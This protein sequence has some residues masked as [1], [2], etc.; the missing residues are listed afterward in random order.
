M[1]N[2]KIFACR[3]AEDF[4]QKV[5]DEIGVELGQK[6]AFKFKND[7]TFV[8]IL[9]TVREDDIFVFQTVQPPVDERIME[10]LITLDALKRASPRRITAVVPYYPYARSDKKDQP[11]V[12]ITSKLVADL[13]VTAGADRVLTCDLHNP[14]IQG[15]IEAPSDQLRAKDILT[16][17]FRP[18]VN[19]DVS[20]FVVVAT[21]AGSSKN[22]YKYARRLGTEIALIDKQRF[23]NDDKAIASHV[24]GDVKEKTCII[25]DDEID[26]AGSMMEAVRVLKDN[27]AGDIYAACTHGVLSGDAIEKIKN[28]AL[29]ELVITNTIPL[30]PEKQLDKIKVLDIAPLFGKAILNIHRGQAVGDLFEDHKME[31]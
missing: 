26:T 10:L 1:N 20:K 8:R 30:P 19:D 17:Y 5:C 27:G 18:M 7:N 14:A 2:L 23:G 3:S 28:P 24:I 13:L 21:D 6:E 11:R 4:A 25:F 16:N 15:F 31:F 22:A 9:E 12:P 29:K